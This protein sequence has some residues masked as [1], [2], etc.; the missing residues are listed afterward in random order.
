MSLS[1][2]DPLPSYAAHWR[3]ATA[4]RAL[5]AAGPVFSRSYTVPLSDGSTL[6]LPLRVLPTGDKA[7]ALLMSNQTSFTVEDALAP[8]M[9][10]AAA[11]LQPEVIAA[12]PT[13]GLDYARLVARGLGMADYVALGHSRKFWYDED[14]SEAATSGTSTKGK[15][16][17]L[18]PAL[19]ERVRGKRVVLVDDVINT[20]VSALSA[21][22]LLERAGAQVV[23]L[24]VV[25]SE[26]HQ[27]RKVLAELGP[28]WQARVKALGHIPMFEAVAGG[29]WKPMANTL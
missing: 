10:Q 29:G 21:I 22:R 12:V 25:L 9:T 23:G 20:G 3:S 26:G 28:Q 6:E 24:T 15:R 18:D 8:L 17:Y 27:W 7:I 16:V 1:S 5:P 4:S 14:L 2:Q 19:V 13:M 11:S